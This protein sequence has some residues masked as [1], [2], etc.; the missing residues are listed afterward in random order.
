MGTTLGMLVADGI[1]IVVGV[2]LCKRIP[3][4]TI[5]WFSAVIFVIF[6]LVGVYEVL[7][8]KIGLGYT[9]LT[10]LLLII[11]SAFA[12]IIISRKQRTSGKNL[13]ASKICKKSA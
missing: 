6:G 9:A 7:S 11:F 10:L 8:T 5:K 2:I 13:E 12:M 1:G 3:E 4:R